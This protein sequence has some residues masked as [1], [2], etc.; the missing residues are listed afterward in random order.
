MHKEII[1][2]KLY[3]YL[4]KKQIKYKKIGRTSATLPCIFCKT[5][6]MQVLPN[7]YKVN[8]F[9]CK[10]K[11]KLGHYYTLLDIA[12]KIENLTG[13]DE[14]ILQ[15]I[16]EELKIN[17]MTNKDEQN[18]DSVLDF[19][20]KNGFD[21]VPII[22]NGKRP[23]ERAW[24]TKNHKDKNE[25]KQWVVNK[26]NLGIKCGQCSNL[27]VIDID[28]KP[29]PE[30]IKKL[31]GTTL[32][33]EST[34]GFH[35]FYKY[36]KDFPKTRIDELKIDIETTGGQVVVNPSL[37]KGIERKI[38]L[39]PII[40]IPKELKKYL[41]DK[42][43]VPRQTD[44]EKIKAD[45][46]TEDFKIDPTKFAL[47]NN[48]L[49]GCCNTEFIKL[50]GILRK[51]L[52]IKNTGYVL[53]VLNKHM[54]ENP[55]PSKNITAM[56]NELSYYSQFDEQELAHEIVEYLKDVDEANRTEIA[57]AIVGAN[58][59]EDK[60]RVD[61]ALKYLVKEKYITKNGSRYGILK[62][63][64]WK[65]SLIETGKVV[66][67]KMPY[68]YDVAN[69]NF[70]DLILIGSKNKKGKSHIAI[71]MIKQL[72]AQGKKP[73]YISL[74]TGNRFA[75]IAMQLGLKEGDFY[76]D[77]Q[78]DPTKIELEKDAIT[79]LDWLCPLNFAETDKIFMHFMEQLYKTNGI[80][81][82]FMQLKGSKG[83][84]NEWFA[85]NMVSQFPALS[86]RYIYDNEGDGEYGK[87]KIDVIR[88]PKLKTKMYEIPCFYNWEEKTLT[89]IDELEN[90]TGETE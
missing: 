72:V 51:Q 8:C 1:L 64:E 58:R 29:I 28:Q 69:F 26:L 53:H 3:E 79:I 46:Q 80:L 66:D 90:R 73:Y 37:V 43:T 68:F 25:W 11:E 31:M 7:S 39:N 85:P 78:I 74:E 13:T 71:N 23:I 35:L 77:F 42:I 87:F 19:Y 22:V 60:K 41:L 89:R 55:M 81:I 62:K 86:T 4:K 48:D 84:D 36:D 16:K 83:Q 10:P 76:W 65:E 33:Q 56:L 54:L 20:E 45:I 9:S 21:L 32:M 75:R 40:E 14:D 63:V 5:G 30:E 38:F 34:K 52:N 44:S 6:T 15:H 67:F 47:K 82:V 70:G 61:K 2:S 50:G 24:T 17:V 18:I 12:R 88:D 57:M 27:L 49:D 59:G